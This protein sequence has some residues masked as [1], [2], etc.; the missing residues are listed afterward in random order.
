LRRRSREITT[1]GGDETSCGTVSLGNCK[2]QATL[3]FSPFDF[4]GSEA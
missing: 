2:M 3:I 4:P 1:L